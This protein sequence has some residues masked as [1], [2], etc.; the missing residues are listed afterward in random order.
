M[1]DTRANAHEQI[2]HHFRCQRC[3]KKF[4]KR[5]SELQRVDEV[6]CPKCGTV[7]DVR[8]SKSTGA[9]GK[10]FDTANEQNK[11]RGPDPDEAA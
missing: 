11:R 2:I 3:G 8:E 7:I 9:I 1:P 6:S 5:L 4:D 10:D